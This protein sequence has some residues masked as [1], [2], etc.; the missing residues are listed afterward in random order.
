MKKIR[1]RFNLWTIPLRRLRSITIV[2]FS[3]FGTDILMMPD[4]ENHFKFTANIEVSPPFFAW[5]S[6]FGRRIKITSP[7]AVLK[8]YR[9][10]LEK[11][12]EMCQDVGEK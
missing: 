10:F 9:E 6:T 1:S 2:I 8:D 5:V 7:A 3:S 4:G 11:S 12:L